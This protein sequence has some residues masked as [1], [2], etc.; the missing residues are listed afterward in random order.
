MQFMQRMEIS[1][2]SQ[3]VIRRARRQSA[4]TLIEL[5]LVL[6]ILGVLA[7]VVVP[8]FTGRTLDAQIKATRT[9]IVALRNAI[10]NF[11]VDAGRFPSTEEG[12]N[13][14]VQRP[15]EVKEW[16][17]PYIEST[18]LKD[19]WGHPFLYQFPGQHNANGFDISSAGPDGTAGTQDDIGNW[20]EGQ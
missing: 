18:D 9:S 11:E 16:H 13:A 7:A 12:L 2:L 6:V 19:T 4:F 8:K 17:G 14:L 15:N 5:L 10:N 3:N 20:A 1:M